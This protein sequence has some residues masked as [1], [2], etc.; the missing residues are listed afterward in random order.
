MNKKLK[1]NCPIE[2]WILENLSS[3]QKAFLRNYTTLEKAAY[4]A[5]VEEKRNTKGDCFRE[6]NS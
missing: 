6:E 5:L 4:K 2:A 1:I 3:G